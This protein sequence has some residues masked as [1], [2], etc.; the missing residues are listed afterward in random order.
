MMNK[1][2]P[3][4]FGKVVVLMGGFSAEREISLVSGNNILN[5]LKRSG[6]DA[7]GLD[8]QENVAE[9]LL[10]MRPD[11][12]FIA[13]HGVGGED[14]TIQGLL[15]YLGIFYTGSGVAAS[16]ITMDKSLCKLFWSSIGIPSLAFRLVTDLESAIEAM[17]FFNLP[18][19]V[20]PAS[21]G[22]SVGVSKVETP[23]QLSEAFEN[24]QAQSFRKRVMIEPWI[25]G[26]EFTVGIL[27][28]NPL[29][30]IEV[31]TPRT[32][33]DF[34]AKYNEHTTSYICPC[35]LLPEKE[36]E[37]Q[38]L[39]FRAFAAVGCSGW[40]RVDLLEDVTGQ[41]WFLEINTIP[42]MTEHSLVP[43]AA[44]VIGLSFDEL[45]LEI[46]SFTLIQERLI[47]QSL[48]S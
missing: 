2:D 37:I 25:E 33:Y 13:L 43:K 14:G 48:E 21:D 23:E 11:R 8:T 18:I 17:E 4:E 5:S 47:L 22:S 6:V 39:A 24:A 19:C 29:P 41:L 38:E 44:S 36:L 35:G 42:G 30:V 40:G 26:K 46:L 1:I 27:G 34:D 20:K 7:Y 45:I 9:E 31:Q 3:M 28:T 15:E 12:A 16:A 10:K 32:F